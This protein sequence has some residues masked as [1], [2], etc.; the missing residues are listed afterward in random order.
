MSQISQHSPIIV[1]IDGPCGSGKSTVGREVADKLSFPYIDTGAMYRS[2]ALFVKNHEIDLDNETAIKEMLNQV[3]I[4]FQEGEGGQRVFLC[5]QDVTSDIRTDEISLMASRVSK[6]PLVR[7]ALVPMQ[8]E[9]AKG[10]KGAVLDGRDVATVIFPEAPVKVFLTAQEEIRA[11]RRF[12][13]MVRRGMNVEFK[14][15]HSDLHKRDM[16]DR[17][18][19]CDPLRQDKDAVLIDSSEL[20]IEQVVQKIVK[21]ANSFL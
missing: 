11:R 20:T 15:V 17:Q 6:I 3:K 16:E 12:D 2:V 19:E 10:K 13:E 1:A 14:Q 18:R 9:V 5:D 4:D 8:R 21:L 7:K